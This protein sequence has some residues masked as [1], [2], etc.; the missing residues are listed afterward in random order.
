MSVTYVSAEL[1]RLVMSRADGLC[2]YCLIAEDDTFF[3]CAID[4][5][6]SEKHGGLTS[7]DNLAYACVVCNQ[8]KGSDVGSIDWETGSFMRFFHPRLDKWSEHF[9]LTGERAIEARTAIGRV[10]ALIF[11]LNHPDRILE[12]QELRERYPSAAATR[13]IMQAL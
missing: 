3:G 6:I 2:E 7:E 4:H 5:I 12:R 9:L 1:R 13:R 8:S 10:T 11:G